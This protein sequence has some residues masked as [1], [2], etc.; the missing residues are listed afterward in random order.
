MYRDV[1]RDVD[2]FRQKDK[3]TYA[4][5]YTEDEVCLS[6]YSENLL[7]QK[8]SPAPLWKASRESEL[9]TVEKAVGCWLFAICQ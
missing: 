5:A 6:F 1:D 4:E 7:P 9:F 2:G 3:A 8:F